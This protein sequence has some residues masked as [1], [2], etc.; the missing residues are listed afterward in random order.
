MPGKSN[1]LEEYRRKRDFRRTGEPRGRGSR[2]RA[3]PAPRFVVQQHD[4]RSMH[5]DFRLETD[6]VLKSWAVPKGPPAD[7]ADKVLAT[8][9][10]DH[11]V[12]YADFEGV[13]PDGEYGAGPVL[14]WD[15]GTYQNLTEDHGE[16]VPVADAISR[17]H[18]TVRLEGEKLHGGYA[19]T[20]MRRRD[21]SQGW[22]LVKMRDGDA[23]ARR[24]PRRARPESVRTGRTIE[25]VAEQG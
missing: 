5:Y 18:L 8:P 14:V 21:G 7:P 23:R 17:G 11:P 4:A 6:G 12:E 15:A 1:H 2:R 16:P 22:L 24:D 10:E 19:L 25:Q 13:I 9:T 3:G 20:R